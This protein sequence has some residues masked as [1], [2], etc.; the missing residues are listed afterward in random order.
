MSCHSA[1]GRLCR[2]VFDVRGKFQNLF[3]P[4]NVFITAQMTTCLEELLVILENHS[5][6][7]ENTEQL[8]SAI[9]YLQ[10]ASQDT[11][12][13][14]CCLYNIVFFCFFNHTQE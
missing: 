9:Y 12:V 13:S 11:S 8:M 14:T 10:D 5:C 1:S 6:V 2:R 4:L 3:C 7:G